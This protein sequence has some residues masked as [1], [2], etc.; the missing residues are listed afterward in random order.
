MNTPPENRRHSR[1]RAKANAK[2]QNPAVRWLREMPDY[3][4]VLICSHVAHDLKRGEQLSQGKTAIKLGGNFM[5]EDGS[6]SHAKYCIACL[7]CT[8]LPAHRVRYLEHIRTDGRFV[9]A[10]ECCPECQDKKPDK[11]DEKRDNSGI[12]GLSH[13]I[14]DLSQQIENHL[15]QIAERFSGYKFGSAVIITA[16]LFVLE[17]VINTCI[18]QPFDSAIVT[19]KEAIHEAAWCIDQKI[20]EREQAPSSTALGDT[21]Q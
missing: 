4:H 6:Q 14:L 20:R 19:L 21:V 9:P 1:R 15:Q 7:G 5:R 8:K 12:I 13:E 3:T 11:P 18:P 16:L 17:R 10:D 2:S